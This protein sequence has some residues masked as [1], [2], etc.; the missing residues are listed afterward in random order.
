[1]THTVKTWSNFYIDQ[2]KGIK[3]FELRKNDRDYKVGDIFISQEYDHINKKYTGSESV[4]TIEY[5]LLSSPMIGLKNGYCIL[6]LKPFNN[7]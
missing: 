6:Q 7:Y 4:F 3:L 1:M 5:I 2:Q